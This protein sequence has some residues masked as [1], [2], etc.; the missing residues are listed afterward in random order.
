MVLRAIDLGAGRVRA[1]S[2][3]GTMRSRQRRLASE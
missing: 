1:F 2:T 3:Q